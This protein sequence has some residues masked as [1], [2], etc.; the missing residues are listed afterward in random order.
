MTIYINHDTK[1][2]Y[3]FKQSA[4]RGSD[5]MQKL[6]ASGVHIWNQATGLCDGCNDDVTDNTCIRDIL[7]EIFAVRPSEV[8]LNGKFNKNGQAMRP[9]IEHELKTKFKS[10]QNYQE[11]VLSALGRT[12]T[13]TRILLLSLYQVDSKMLIWTLGSTKEDSTWVFFSFIKFNENKFLTN[14][15]MRNVP[16]SFDEFLEELVRVGDNAVVNVYECDKY[17]NAKQ[18]PVDYIFG[19]NLEDYPEALDYYIHMHSDLMPAR[20]VTIYE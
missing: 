8:K 16:A 6:V 5:F 14:L 18:T 10:E 15:Q 7:D 3:T 13:D 4:M 19:I 2:L 20:K 17:G 11:W 12:T 1:V 9:L